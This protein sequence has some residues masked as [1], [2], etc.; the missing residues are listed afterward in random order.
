MVPDDLPIDPPGKSRAERKRPRPNIGAEAE[1]RGG[2]EEPADV[3][4]EQQIRQDQAKR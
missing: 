2:S 4:I 1:V 3:P